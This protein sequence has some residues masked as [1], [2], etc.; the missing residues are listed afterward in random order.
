MLDHLKIHGGYAY[1]SE[2]PKSRICTYLD[3]PGAL[4]LAEGTRLQQR[5]ADRQLYIKGGVTVPGPVFLQTGV[6]GGSCIYVAL[7]QATFETAYVLA[8]DWV[9]VD[10]VDAERMV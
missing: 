2:L 3:L 4:H 6:L 10:V 8:T 5:G 1:R 7:Q 9:V